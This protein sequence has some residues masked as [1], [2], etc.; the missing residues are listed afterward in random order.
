MNYIFRWKEDGIYVV[1]SRR[2]TEQ[3][4]WD[5]AAQNLIPALDRPPH[6]MQWVRKHGEVIKD[7][8]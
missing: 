1:P 5:Y 3:E 7:D 6:P 8:E 4:V 2:E